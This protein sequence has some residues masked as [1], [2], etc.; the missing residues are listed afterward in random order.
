MMTIYVGNMPLSWQ[1]DELRQMFS[2]F[3]EVVTVAIITDRETGASRG[4]GFVE[5]EPEAA[6]SAI[7]ALDGE[8]IQGCFLR[9]NQARDRGARPPRR[10]Y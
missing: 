8:E 5:M 1:D 3:G 10:E 4:F 9:V 7:A 6:A 2:R